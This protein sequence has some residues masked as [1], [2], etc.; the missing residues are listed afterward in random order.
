MKFLEV[1][2]TWLNR[3]FANE[4]A[5]YLVV[6]IIVSMVV[7]LTIGQM[8]APVFTGLIIAFLLQGLVTSLV[9]FKVPQIL[10]VNLAF[11]LFLGALIAAVLFIFP[12]I[13]QQGY[14]FLNSLPEI[15]GQLKT[16]L[17]QLPARYP[18]LLSE[19]QVSAWLD[20]AIAELSQIGPRFV[21]YSLASLPSLM[22][23]FIY[24]ILVPILVF[25]FLKDRRSLM[26]WFQSLLPAERP[27]LDQVGAVMS[28]QMANYARGKVVEIM[29]V[30]VVTYI[31]FALLGLKYA[32]FL[33]L[34]VGISVIVPFIGAAV[35]TV[36]VAL[37]GFVQWGWSL[38]FAYMMITYSIIQ[39]LD[40]NVLVPILFS[41]AVDLHPVTIIVAVLA[42]GGLWGLWGVFFAIPLATLIK[43]IYIAWP[44]QAVAEAAD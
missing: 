18:G 42:F 39:A 8:L 29:I 5:I 40:G 36:P 6:F 25:F 37:L 34:I 22:V 13:S 12:I 35:V 23:L 9:R 3:H 11:L 44:R 28:R 26:A 41:E 4:E 19:A 31:A 1:I 30:G 27:L 21:Q 38:E 16:T 10:A 32:A 7:L 33:A 17:Q 15:L 24:F 14:A 43:A 20:V 2:G